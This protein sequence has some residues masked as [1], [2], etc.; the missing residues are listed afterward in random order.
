MAAPK[1]KT[2]PWS[3]D[4]NLHE[5]KIIEALKQRLNDK[6]IKDPSIAKK[7]A[8][9]IEEWLRQKSSK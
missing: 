8:L 2:M 6:I 1:Y 4:K 5:K 7:A 9:I 3:E